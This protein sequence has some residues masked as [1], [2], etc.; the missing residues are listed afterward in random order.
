MAEDLTPRSAEEACLLQEAF[1]IPAPVWSSAD[2]KAIQVA[3]VIYPERYHMEV[4]ALGDSHEA[5]RA[6]VG[7]LRR[8]ALNLAVELDVHQISRKAAA[9][10]LRDAAGGNDG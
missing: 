7:E 8:V 5:L 4:A 1:G 6:Q 10:R 2:V 9:A 3:S